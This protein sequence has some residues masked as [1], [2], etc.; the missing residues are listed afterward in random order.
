MQSKNKTSVFP[1]NRALRFWTDFFMTK[2]RIILLFDRKT[3][4]KKREK[5][6][7]GRENKKKKHQRERRAATATEAGGKGGR[8]PRG[9]KP[10]VSTGAVVLHFLQMSSNQRSLFLT[11]HPKGPQQFL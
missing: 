10:Q 5:G 9:S 4:E 8:Y 6:G 11:M 7:E 3:R 1:Q 2:A